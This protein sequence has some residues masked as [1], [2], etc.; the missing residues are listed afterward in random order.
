MGWLTNVPNIKK[1]PIRAVLFWV[2]TLFMA[3]FLAV[4][5]WIHNYQ[6]KRLEERKLG[7][8]DERS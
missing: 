4:A 8:E 5:M 1:N 7:N 6:S 2:F 3:P